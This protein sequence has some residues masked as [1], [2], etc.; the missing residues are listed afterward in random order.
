[1]EFEITQMLRQDGGSIINNSSV[2]GL[3]GSGMFPTYST[4]KRGVVV[5]TKSAALQYGEQGIRV[6]AVCP[7]WI[8]PEITSAWRDDAEIQSRFCSRQALKR[9]G[10]PEEIA[11]LVPWLCSDSAS[12]TTGA[13][14]AVDGGLIA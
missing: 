13:T 9:H 5:L 8:D 6:N 1:M 4:M 10:E 14:F 12:F 7:G 3:K 2:A 11:G